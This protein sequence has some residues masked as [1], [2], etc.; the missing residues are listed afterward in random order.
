MCSSHGNPTSSSPPKRPADPAILAR[1]ADAH[2]HP[3]DDESFEGALES[4]ASSKLGTICAM[5]SSLENQEITTKLW[6]RNKNK[7][8]PCYGLH[9][10]FIHSL[11][12]SDSPTVPTREEHYTTLFPS[13]TDVSQPSP[14]LATLLSSLPPPLLL[15]NFLSTLTNNLEAHP[16]ALLGEIGLDKAFRIPNPPELASSAKNSDL[17]TPL[18]HQIAVAEAQIRV[19]IRL[20]RHLSFH[21]V[22]APQ[23][24]VRLLER[25]RGEPDGWGRVHVCLHSFGGSP[26]TAKQVQK[27]HP[28]AFFSFST[29]ISGRSPRF[30]ELLRA[31]NAD[32]LL[33]ES[34]FSHTSQLDAQVWEVF[35][36]IC[37]AREWS[38]EE[39]VEQLETNWRKFLELEPD[40]M[41]GRRQTKK[42]RRLEKGQAAEEVDEVEESNP[43]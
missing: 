10:W 29:I 42:Q 5:S 36:E 39:C 38:A 4:I 17:Q 13:S 3:S 12:L 7:I 33:V 40:G 8:L 37:E 19:A 2:C 25:I 9:P 24:T 20:E 15:S 32:R 35:E 28:N 21:S 41:G 23:D 22:R 1:L 11:S 18:A 43:K 16:T 14:S 26:E 31:I 34:D 6:E 27:M 30:H